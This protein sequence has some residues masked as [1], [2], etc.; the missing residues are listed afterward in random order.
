VLIPVAP[1]TSKM[2]L[3]LALVVMIHAQF[4]PMPQ[5]VPV[6]QQIMFF[7]AHNA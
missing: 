6:A 4:A 3:K 1:A 5:P 2:G 7:K